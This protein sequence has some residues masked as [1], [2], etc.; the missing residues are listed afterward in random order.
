MIYSLDWEFVLVDTN[1]QLAMTCVF[2]C[3]FLGQALQ[4]PLGI[5]FW[6]QKKRGLEANM[7]SKAAMVRWHHSVY[8][9]HQVLQRLNRCK[10]IVSVWNER[11]TTVRILLDLSRTSSWRA[12]SSIFS[13]TK[14][15]FGSRI[16]MSWTD[17][18]CD[19]LNFP[20]PFPASA[21]IDL[22]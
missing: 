2:C 16:E 14:K 6:D 18:G 9:Y 11:M 19:Y 5:P 20:R 1:S 8:N 22:F 13:P 3:W 7:F 21:E 12:F 4:Y 17:H 15:P 10:R